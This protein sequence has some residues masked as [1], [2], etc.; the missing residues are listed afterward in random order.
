MCDAV[1]R[2][3]DDVISVD[4]T[5]LDFMRGFLKERVCQNSSGPTQLEVSTDI[6][7]SSI[8]AETC[9]HVRRN[10]VTNTGV[11]FEHSFM[12]CV[13]RGTKYSRTRL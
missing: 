6:A 11:F 10:G 8:M 2:L 3:R 12:F 4:P 9:T 1:G 5:T 13:E 7:T